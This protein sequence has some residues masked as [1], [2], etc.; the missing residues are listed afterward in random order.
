MTEI[1]PVCGNALGAGNVYCSICGARRSAGKAANAA[2]TAGDSAVAGK[3]PDSEGLR[4]QVL[5][6]LDNGE[7]GEAWKYCCQAVYAGNMKDAEFVML[8]KALSELRHEGLVWGR[9]P[10][11]KHLRQAGL[12]NSEAVKERLL[13]Y[14]KRLEN[15]L[16]KRRQSKLELEKRKSERQEH[17]NRSKRYK[18]AA[19][20]MENAASEEEF[21]RAASSFEA[22]GDFSDAKQKRRNCIDKAMRFHEKA[23]AERQERLRRQ[24]AARETI[25]RTVLFAVCLVV[26][27]AAGALI[28][29]L[30]DPD[31]YA[32]KGEYFKA[33][34]LYKKRKDYSGTAD[35]YKK[36]MDSGKY[37]EAAD[38]AAGVNAAWEFESA[39]AYI[40]SFCDKGDGAGASAAYSKMASAHRS[41]LL[42]EKDHE[43]R[44]MIAWCLIKSGNYQ[45]A[46]KFI[47]LNDF[48]VMGKYEQ[49]GDLKNG[50][51]D[52]YWRV[53]Q[54]DIE[55]DGLHLTLVSSVA[56]DIMPFNAV[57]T[58][59]TWA[60]CSLRAWLNG[61][62]Y[63]NSFTKNERSSIVKCPLAGERNPRSVARAGG[64]TMDKIWLLSKM[65]AETYYLKNSDKVCFASKYAFYKDGDF[66]IYQR[67]D[68]WGTPK[69]GVRYWLRTPGTTNVKAADV[70]KNGSV[71]ANA[72]TFNERDVTDRLAVRP[73]MR[74]VLSKARPPQSK[75]CAY[76]AEREI[77]EMEKEGKDDD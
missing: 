34:Q 70:E 7:A 65:E 26:L 44:H 21:R 29:T 6:S 55:K 52:I 5:F 67:L 69:W 41:V 45:E 13:R 53:K 11:R 35:M 2:G 36:L 10:F 68:A 24:A 59:V 38:V 49:D 64:K 20:L 47:K 12:E 23:E 74:V 73:A 33:A 28:A 14:A 72:L 42:N 51:E 56:L 25:K 63:E 32:K 62:F 31:H 8:E 75:P 48:I 15:V 54:S 77:Q 60:T 66:G 3:M 22:L 50:P 17:L 9:R 19:R 46:C 43:L 18:E 37:S 16:V 30:S 39:S 27:V 57:K 4:R 76:A 61:K 71:Y 58:P 1:C 40:K